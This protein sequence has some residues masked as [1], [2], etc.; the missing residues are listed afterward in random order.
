MP[1][2]IP[3]ADTQRTGLVETITLGAVVTLAFLAI[4]RW[5]A[6]QT[7]HLIPIKHQTAE[8]W[9]W[10]IL[11]IAV[12]FGLLLTCGSWKRSG[13]RIGRFRQHWRKVLLVCSVPIALTA[14][15][16][17]NLT[18]RPFA[19]FSMAVWVID[20]LAQEL[21]FTGYIYGRLEQVANVRIY[22]RLPFTWAILL[23]AV[24]F[25][26]MHLS[27]LGYTPGGYIIFMLIYTFLGGML[28]GLVRLWT[29]S[30]LYGVVTHMAVNFVPWI[31]G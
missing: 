18:T 10:Y 1:T 8:G 29:G 11:S 12:A 4:P 3:H 9:H 2:T 23:S 28:M 24:L 17:P 31:T 19:N 27:H 7:W 20:P 15:V 22:R 14:A 5:L 30:I 25:S 26:L 13:L 6:E 21:V 16:Y